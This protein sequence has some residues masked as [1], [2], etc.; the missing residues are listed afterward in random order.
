MPKIQFGAVMNLT[1]ENLKGDWD[2]LLRL[3]SELESQEYRRAFVMDHL[4]GTRSWV[5]DHPDFDSTSEFLECWTEVAALAASTKRIR[6]GPLVQCVGFRNPAL[7]AKIAA[8]VDRISSGRLEFS[9]GAGWKEDE[10]VSYGYGFEKPSIRIARLREALTVV[11]L[12]WTRKKPSFKGKFFEIDNL[13]FGPSLVQEPHP[14]VW[15]GGGGEKLLLKVVAEHADIWD[16]W[17]GRDQYRH[18]LELL[19]GYCD[20]LGR[21]FSEIELSF[22][23]EVFIKESG[24]EALRRA[25]R[26]IPPGADADRF[27]S[28]RIVGDPEQ[29]IEQIGEFAELGMKHFSPMI[30][31]MDA[32][33]RILFAERIIPAFS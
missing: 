18:K 19:E 26:A 32:S 31:T 9:M 3:V 25:K 10:H 22:S 17:C 4:T 27:L 14:P 33:D 6:L 7:V 5:A 21:K 2:A 20:S 24:D 28:S 15:I 11:K 1:K 8:S 13:E 30:H 12:A 16:V 29:C 23:P